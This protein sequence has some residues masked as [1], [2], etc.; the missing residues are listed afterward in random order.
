M[1]FNYFKGNRMKLLTMILAAM[2][3]F[4][5]VG[6]AFAEDAAPAKDKKEEK[7]AKGK[8]GEKKKD[9]DSKGDKKEDKK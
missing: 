7:K 5:T 8:K 3:T 2:F 6:V 4:G 1:S 9:K